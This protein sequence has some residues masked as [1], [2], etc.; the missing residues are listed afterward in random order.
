M[1]TSKSNIEKGPASSREPSYLSQQKRQYLV[2][3]RSAI[4]NLGVMS[5]G[6]QNVANHLKSLGV[7]F[8]VVKTLRGRSGAPPLSPLGFGVARGPEILVARLNPEQGEALRLQSAGGFSPIVVEQDS[9][10]AYGTA[11]GLKQ[12]LIATSAA[13]AVD[14]TG[15]K[16]SSIRIQVLGDGDKPLSRVAVSVYGVG[17]PSEGLSDDNGQVEL[18]LY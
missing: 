11:T 6:P 1:S 10:L 4:A 3:S 5:V 9:P 15:L 18:P 8:D 17:L 13:I 14:R 2:A 12:A 16:P 7:E